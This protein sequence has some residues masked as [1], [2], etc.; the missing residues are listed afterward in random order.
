M[1]KTN[2]NE[3]TRRDFLKLAGGYVVSATLPKLYLTDVDS[4]T[5]STENSSTFLDYFPET[6]GQKVWESHQINLAEGE[7]FSIVNFSKDVVC[8]P[9]RIKHAYSKLRDYT[10]SVPRFEYQGLTL[11]LYGFY[12]TGDTIVGIVPENLAAHGTQTIPASLTSTGEN[13]IYI[14]SSADIG[15]RKEFKTKNDK[16]S[17]MLLNELINTLAGVAVENSKSPVLP[18][19]NAILK[20]VVVNSTSRA[21]S[22]RQRGNTWEQYKSVFDAE[23]RLIDPRDGQKYEFLI[24]NK[25]EYYNLPIITNPLS[26][27]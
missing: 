5:I 7:S 2:K 27:I 24:F 11:A 25:L 14:K 18:E 1:E 19:Q 13:L 15:D 3:L 10:K 20:E 12:M 23:I 16:I 8:Y 17:A 9:L 22:F 26:F 6:K 4:D 21:L